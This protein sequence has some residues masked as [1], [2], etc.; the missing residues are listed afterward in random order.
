MLETRYAHIHAKK[1]KAADI[2]RMAEIIHDVFLQLSKNHK[3]GVKSEK[4]SKYQPL[5]EARFRITTKDNVEYTSELESLQNSGILDT[6][7]IIMAVLQLENHHKDIAV[8]LADSLATRY[9]SYV[10]VKGDD[11]TWVNGIFGRLNEA[12]N[13]CEDQKSAIRI[14]RWPISVIL[15]VLGGY[16]LGWLFTLPIPLS[17]EIRV[18]VGTIVSMVGFFAILFLFEDYLSKLWPDVE[19]V[20]V[21]E[22]QRVLDRRRKSLKWIVTAIFIPFAI[23]AIVS[24]LMH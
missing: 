17:Q 3:A 15:G 14:F 24:W 7:V 9:S 10:E 23:S 11:S 8:S 16:F 2:R 20:P 21:S 19:I 1:I 6:K 5:P 12:I 4:I 18:L 13:A 22:H